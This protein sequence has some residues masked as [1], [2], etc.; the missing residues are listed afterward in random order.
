MSRKKSIITKTDM[1]RLLFYFP[2]NVLI[3]FSFS[4]TE[5]YYVFACILIV[6]N[7]VLIFA[8]RIYC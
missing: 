4:Q 8:I 1:L 3:I 7:K 5:Y 2:L 6:Y